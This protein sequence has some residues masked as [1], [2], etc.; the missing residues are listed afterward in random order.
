M[1]GLSSIFSLGKKALL[2][3]QV[4]IHVTGE[5]IAN[6][7]NPDYSRQRVNLVSD[8]FVHSNQGFI[9]SGVKVNSVDRI[10]DRFYDSQVWEGKSQLAEWK[11]GGKYG[12]LI[13]SIFADLDNSG[14]STQLNAFW[15][16]WED[17]GNH[18]GDYGIRNDVRLKAQ[19]VVN[20]L[21][22]MNSR[23]RSVSD[24]ALSEIQGSLVKINDLIDQ[25]AD[26]N[27]KIANTAF[28]ENSNTLLDRR[29]A[30]IDKL[31]EY[32]DVVAIVHE[33]GTVSVLSSYNTV[34]DQSNA[35]SLTLDVT[36]N[37]GYRKASLLVDG[38]MPVEMKSGQLKNLM[39]IFST[40]VPDL[41]QKL[42]TITERS[43][44]HTSELQSH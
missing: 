3:N 10:R 40:G 33:N 34:V 14:L 25:I 9:G 39:D 7:Q 31:S 12:N 36:E 5:N 1:G 38:T 42:D 27:K 44:E 20:Q 15:N 32:I 6:A 30:L 2:S 4:G 17:L 26:T 41:L 35:Y 37:N 8:S 16:A 43:E 23:L 28:S 24:N 19:G 11:S 13:Q 22:G 18:P 21:H 29:D